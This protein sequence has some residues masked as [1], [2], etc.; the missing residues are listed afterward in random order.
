MKPSPAIKNSSAWAPLLFPV[1][2][3]IWLA[4]LVSNIGT[5]MEAVGESWLM[6]TLTTNPLLISLIQASI[7]LPIFLL[8]LPAGALADILDRRRY[9]LILQIIMCITV[10]ILALITWFQLISP[11]TLLLMAFI[12][13]VFTAFSGPTW[14][15]IVPELIPKELLPAAIILNSAAINVARIAGPALAG[16]IIATI[17][18]AA[19]FAINSLSFLGIIIVLKTWHPEPVIN[20]LPVERFYSAMRVGL[21]YTLNSPILRNILARTFCFF[22]FSSSVMALL[23]L[24]VRKELSRGPESYG[25]MVGLFGLG[26]IVGVLLLPALRRKCNYDRLITLGSIVFSLSGLIL[27]IG[28]FFYLDCLALFIAG[29]AWLMVLSTFNTGV[30]LV[31]PSWV[32][33]RASSLYLA[34]LSLGM[35]IG[36]I[37]W[38]FVA[39]QYSVQVAL[40]A[41]VIGLI[42]TTGLVRF[43]SLDDISTI[44]ITPTTLFSSPPAIDKSKYYHGPVMVMIE[45]IIDP[46]QHKVFSQEMLLMRD[47]RLRDGSF[48]WNLFIDSDNPKKVVECFMVESWLEHLRQHERS[49][50]YDEKIHRKIHRFHKASKPPKVSHLIGYK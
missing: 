7:A 31:A 23:P 42:I 44:D 36:S 8:A 27:C 39:S 10:L 18:P 11:A 33:A 28:K 4:A 45:Y 48:F 3:M 20:S 2:K 47:I 29:I 40:F 43:F 34:I 14:Q 15:A 30:L 35:V 24:L 46:E 25:L 19:V 49:T 17:G 32:R 22:I 12:I 50:A 37:V 16:I 38:G 1:F 13:G 41:S 26:A 5:W 21:R 9:L 6:A